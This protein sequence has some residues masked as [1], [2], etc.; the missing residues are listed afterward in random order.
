MRGHVVVAVLTAALLCGVSADLGAC[1]DKYMRVGQSIR[2]RLWASTH[3]SSILVYKPRNASSAGVKFYKELLTNAGHK[4]D[5]VKFGTPLNKV[6][7]GRTYDVVLIHYADLPSVLPQLQGLPRMPVIVP[8][9][10]DQ[11]KP[12]AAQAGREYPFLIVPERMDPFMALEQI[13]LSIEQSL[14]KAA[15]PATGR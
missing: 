6:M 2:L 15:G 12:V 8:I 3:P 13:D 7:A 9:L 11:S 5:F 4:P 14:T 1:G 10:G